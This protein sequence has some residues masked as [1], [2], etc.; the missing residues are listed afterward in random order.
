[1]SPERKHVQ[2]AHQERFQLRRQIHH[3]KQHAAGAHK[4]NNQLKCDECM[5]IRLLIE[6][7]MK[8]AHAVA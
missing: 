2:V 8:A 1:M 5:S 3:R 7:R 4:G 6:E